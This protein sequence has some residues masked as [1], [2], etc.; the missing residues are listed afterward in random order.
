MLIVYKN[1]LCWQTS[2][3]V[4]PFYTCHWCC[5][6]PM[7]NGWLASDRLRG[8]SHHWQWQG[9]SW[10]IYSIIHNMS[11]GLVVSCSLEYLGSTPNRLQRFMQLFSRFASLALE[12]LYEFANAREAILGNVGK[13]ASSKPHQYT[14]NRKQCAWILECAVREMTMYT[15][16]LIWNC[17]S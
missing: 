15:N 6:F 16:L 5:H 11:T 14:P 7:I 3:C 4:L 13:I 17:V 8:G 12:H 9:I 1:Y 10:Y 2:S